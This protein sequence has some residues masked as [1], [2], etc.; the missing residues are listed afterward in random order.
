[1]AFSAWI[2]D[3]TAYQGAGRGIYQITNLQIPSDS[4]YNDKCTFVSLAG[5]MIFSGNRATKGGSDAYGLIKLLNPDCDCK[6]R[7][8][9][10]NLYSDSHSAE[11]FPFNNTDPLSSISTD[12]VM[13]CFCNTSIHLLQC[14]ERTH[15]KSV[16]SGMEI[17]AIR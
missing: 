12:P 2:C 16:Y 17:N 6:P 4:N 10:K 1:M 8:R 3:N 9:N 11:C 5:S 13:V 14:S 15:H 7:V